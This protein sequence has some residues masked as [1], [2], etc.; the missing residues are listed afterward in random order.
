MRIRTSGIGAFVT[1]AA[2]FMLAGCAVLEADSGHKPVT[3]GRAGANPEQVQSELMSFTDTFI[4]S[5]S[6]QW[7]QADASAAAIAGSRVPPTPGAA[8]VTAA[9]DRGRRASLEIKIANVT[10]AL[11]IATSPNPVVGLA[12]MITMITLERM[13]LEDP[14]AGETFGPEK[15][16]RLVFVY[17]E[18]EEKAWRIADHV[19]TLEQQKDLRS[20]I[21]QWRQEHPTQRYIAGVRLEDFAR[22]RGTVHLAAGESAPGSLLALVGLDPLA[23]LDPTVREVQRSRLLAERV[24]FYSQHAPSLIKW[25]TES[26]YTGLLQTPEVKQAMTSIAGVSAAADNVADAADQLRQ[27]L[28]KE[29]HDALVDLFAQFHKERQE[30]MDQFFKGIADERRQ[31]LKDIDAGADKLGGT[32]KQAREAAEATEQLTTSLK[33]TIQAADAL[34]ARFTPPAGTAAPVDATPKKDA[35]AE[36]REAAALTAQ[37]VDKLTVLADRVDKILASPDLDARTGKLRTVVDSLQGGVQ[38]TV[39]HAFWWLLAIA[40]VG[41]FCLG[42]A[43]TLGLSGHKAMERRGAAKRR[44]GRR[45]N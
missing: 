2:A 20:I 43:I 23:N 41:S 31:T 39:D 28:S 44:A 33:A 25:Q 37:T 26:L 15:A 12:D 30:A 45:G 22:D 13:I 14:W 42:A 11:D 40:V 27:D 21:A 6:Q 8:P 38:R 24:F 4:S 36:Y 34:A 1:A 5:I 29:R 32:L 19:F 7:N 16:A 10:G 17:K 35:I 3:L 9:G 18:Q